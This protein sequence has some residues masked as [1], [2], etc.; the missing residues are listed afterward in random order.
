[1]SRIG[2]SEL[3]QYLKMGVHSTRAKLLVQASFWIAAI[4]VGGMAV[5]FTRWIEWLQANYVALQE[6]HPVWG[7]LLTP[8]AFVA[9]TW[10]CRSLEPH[11]GGSG[12]PQVLHAVHLSAEAAA[13]SRDK[14]SDVARGMLSIRTAL[15]KLVSCTIGFIGG[16]SI[17]G[18]GPT[19]QIS[20]SIFSTIGH[21]LRRTFPNLDLQSYLVAGAGAGIAAAFNAPLGGVTFALEEVAVGEFGAQD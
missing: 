14:P 6:A 15:V 18:E 8:A 7:T 11:A 16:A 19:V 21:R 1:M 5:Y 2:S 4:A 20:A 12:I 9:A 3:G 17:G 10:V 13:Q